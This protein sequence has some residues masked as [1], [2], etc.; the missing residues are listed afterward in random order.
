MNKNKIAIES[1]ASDLKRV[2]L[3]RHRGS[4]QAADRFSAE[5][6][7]R[8]DEI[9]LNSTQPYIQKILKGVPTAILDSDTALMY[10]TLLQN[11]SLHHYSPTSS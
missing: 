9:D 6:K 7:K 1:L 3:L 2:A 4:I 10:S 5:A 11:Y 8:V